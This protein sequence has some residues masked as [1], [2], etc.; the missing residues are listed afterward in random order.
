MIFSLWDD[1]E[2]NMLWLDSAYPLDRPVTDPGIKWG[3][4]PGGETSTPT[5]LR[6][7]YPNGGVVFKNAAVGEIGS[8]YVLP[9]SPLL[10]AKGASPITTRIVFQRHMRMNSYLAILCGY[11]MVRSRAALRYG[12]TVL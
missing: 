11:L 5:Y 4:C 3:D 1:V 8:T 10:K 6:E 2:V 7:K 9:Q 12:V